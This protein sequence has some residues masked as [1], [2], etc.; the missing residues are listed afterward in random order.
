[1]NTFMYSLILKKTIFDSVYS[2]IVVNIINYS[3]KKE[4]V[5][6]FFQLLNKTMTLLNP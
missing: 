6:L 1:M 5:I 2:T 4:L 3:F